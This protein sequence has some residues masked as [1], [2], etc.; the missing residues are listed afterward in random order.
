MGRTHSDQ[1]LCVCM[2]NVWSVRKKEFSADENDKSFTMSSTTMAVTHLLS[3]S[4]SLSF[5]K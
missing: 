1:M 3:L 5:I 4:L 2:A